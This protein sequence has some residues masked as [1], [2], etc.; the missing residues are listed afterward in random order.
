MVACR[1]DQALEDAF[2]QPAV[3]RIGHRLLLN[4]GVYTHP[5]TV[6]IGQRITAASRVDRLGQQPLVALLTQSIASARQ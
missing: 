6:T 2:V 1:L 5:F 3:Q 4:R